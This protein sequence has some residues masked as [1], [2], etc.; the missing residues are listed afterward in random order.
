MVAASSLAELITLSEDDCAIDRRA[1]LRYAT[2]LRPHC[3]LQPLPSE[4][5]PHLLHTHTLL[6]CPSPK[7]EG[8]E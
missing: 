2:E 6:S 1:E 4:T 7:G 5:T 3:A 8:V